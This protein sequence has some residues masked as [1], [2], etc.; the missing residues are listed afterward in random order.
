ML[1]F[2]SISLVKVRQVLLST[3]LIRHVNKNR[4]STDLQLSEDSNFFHWSLHSSSQFSVKSM[5]VALVIN[6]GYCVTIYLV[7]KITN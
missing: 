4:E 1:L 3:N 5:Y 7:C 2:L 6:G